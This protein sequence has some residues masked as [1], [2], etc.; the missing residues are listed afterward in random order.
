VGDIHQLFDGMIAQ[1]SLQIEKDAPGRT[2]DYSDEN[3]ARRFSACH[4]DDL[5]FVDTW[6][7]WLIWDATRWR[8]DETLAVF[9]HARTRCPQEQTIPR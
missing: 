6:G 8:F 1:N 7:R 3:L 4:K 9:A 5:R 2:A